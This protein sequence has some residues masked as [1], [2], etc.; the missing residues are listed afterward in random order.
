MLA[1][2]DFPGFAGLPTTGD[3]RIA[4]FDWTGLVNLNSPFCFT[5]R[6]I[7]F[8]GQL[9]TGVLPYVQQETPNQYPSGIPGAQKAGPIPLGDECGAAGLSTDKSCPEGGIA[10]NGDFMT[11]VSQAQGQIWGATSTEINQTF[12]SEASPEMREGAVYFRSRHPNVRQ[13]RGL[14]PDEPGVCIADA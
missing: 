6:G 11:Q 7:R 13:V 12:S 10:T 5:C 14:R 1:A 9:F 3:N 4:V 8:G 2:L